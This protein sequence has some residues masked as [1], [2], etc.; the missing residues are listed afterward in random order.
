VVGRR[1]GPSFRELELELLAGHE[2]ALDELE[3]F[4]IAHGASPSSW[5][6]KLQHV[7][8]TLPTTPPP[9]TVADLVAAACDHAVQRLLLHDPALRLTGDV[10]AV[11]QARVATRR[12]RSDLRSLR[13]FL[14][15]DTARGLRAEL[16]WLAG[17]LGAVRDLDVIAA[18]IDF[19]IAG[20]DE[21]APSARQLLT[22]M[23][24]AERAPAL[25]EVR[26]ALTSPRYLALVAAVRRAAE[27]PPLAADVDP[28]LPAKPAAKVV[29]ARSWR[30]VRRVGRP[31]RSGAHEQQLHEL[32]KLAK[33]AR[34]AHELVAPLSG[35][36]SA[37]R[38]QHIEAMQD[39]L[40]ELQDTVITRA[41]LRRAV[42]GCP[43]DVAFV[44][45]RLHEREA[46]RAAELRAAWQRPFR[47]ADGV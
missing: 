3:T 12:L 35:T 34:Y 10:E 23:L 22:A 14:D 7:L 26:A 18:R 8:G 17:V 28:G 15:R 6:S 43:P 9:R 41:W 36:R 31:L 32:R 25:D 21:P 11:H 19:G 37:T 30:G 46:G 24:A 38:R 29:T 13:P 40:G 44:A 16:A 2:A 42:A 4:L 39:V 20:L 45:G 47:A 27:E 5:A 33:Q 1:A